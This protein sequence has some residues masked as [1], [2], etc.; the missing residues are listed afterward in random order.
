MRIRIILIVFIFFI[1]GQGLLKSQ[2][3][4]EQINNDLEN[5]FTHCYK[6]KMFNGCIAV[7]MKGKEIFRKCYGEKG[8]NKMELN[9]NTPFLLASL[10]KQFTAMGIQLLAKEK[11][12]DFNDKAN[13][14]LSD[15]PYTEITIK[16]LLNQTSGLFEYENFL[17]GKID[18]IKKAHFESGKT[19]QNKDILEL[20]K[21]HKPPL[22]F[23]PGSEFNYCNTNYILLALI[24]EKV[25]DK[26]FSAFIKNR[27][28]EPLN[29]NNSFV[30]DGKTKP[31][32]NRAV[33]FKWSNNEKSKSLND[34]YPFLC[35]YGDG[36][37]F[38]SII[39]LQKWNL[40]L[41][42]NALLSKK[43][44]ETGFSPPKIKEEYS[45]YGFGWFVRQLPFNGNKATT[46]SGE[47][48]GFSNAFFKDLVDKNSIILLSNN[49][50]NYRPALNTTLIR[51][52]YGAPFNL[53]KLAS[54]HWM[55]KQ[56]SIYPI[57]Q[58]IE[59]YH[60][61]HQTSKKN[62]DFQEK[63]LNRL[64]YDLMNQD[65]IKKAIKIFELNVQYYP[66]SANVYDS[67]GEA[68]LK[69]GEKEAAILNYKKSIEIDSSNENAI[70]IIKE[71][72][73]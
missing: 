53:P 39:D 31:T 66:N 42:N 16:Q 43:E 21:K 55:T 12:L 70:K 10:S 57:D 67:L 46:H 27:I 54:G 22:L 32:A 68:L 28:F 25:S 49:S 64:G 26:S 38:S 15:F 13:K 56:I 2:P 33:G 48:V 8:L 71:L 58:A 69:D 47:F 30:L 61:E 52:L 18:Q 35:T 44:T 1:Y 45:P 50:S 11:L 23:E 4:I 9:A 19:I 36:G 7:N 62:L 29:M 17:N 3:T 51:I 34:L 73:Q 60:K 65:E 37:I 6:N 41:D 20:L 5:L 24:I 59:R 72:K 14:H 40:A 63:H